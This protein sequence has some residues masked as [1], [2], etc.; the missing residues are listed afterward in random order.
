MWFIRPPGYT[1][2]KSS[3]SVSGWWIAW[4]INTEKEGDLLSV[5]ELRCSTAPWTS[6]FKITGDWVSLGKG[7]NF[8]WK[9]TTFKWPGSWRTIKLSNRPIIK[10]FIW[11]IFYCWA[12]SCIFPPFSQEIKPLTYANC[13]QGMET[14]GLL[15]TRRNTLALAHSL[16]EARAIHKS[17]AAWA[18]GW[19]KTSYL[20]GLRLRNKSCFW[21]TL[22]I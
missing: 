5:V 10:S 7:L 2:T 9:P 15:N 17:W 4:V 21:K 19:F 13:W 11:Q 1:S 6:C 14:D 8:Y 22:C 18:E 12:S 16:M 20:L 3:Q